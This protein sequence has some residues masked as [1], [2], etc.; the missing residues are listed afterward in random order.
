MA[1]VRVDEEV[2]AVDDLAVRVDEAA[3][4]RSNPIT[5]KKISRSLA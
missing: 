5:K 3:T 4:S 2:D 1:A